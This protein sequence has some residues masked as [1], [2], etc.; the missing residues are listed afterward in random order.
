MRQP[1]LKDTKHE[2]NTAYLKTKYMVYI[3]APSKISERSRKKNRENGLM[4]DFSLRYFS[5][6]VV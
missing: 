3:P 5:W 6:M 2:D 1:S 4:G